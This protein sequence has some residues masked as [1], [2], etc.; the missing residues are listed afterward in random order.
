MAAPIDPFQAAFHSVINDFKDKLS[1]T[2]LYNEIL[3][4]TSID[5]VYDATDKLQKK[6]AEDGHLRHLSKIETYLERLREYSGAIDTFV[7]TKPSVLAL[8]WG[9]IKLLIQWTS[10]LKQSFDAIIN[11]TE[12]IGG[13]L[14]EFKEVSQ[15][16]SHNVQLKDVLVLFFQDILDFY[17]VALQFF[18]KP[19]KFLPWR[20]QVPI[21]CAWSFDKLA[22]QGWRYVFESLWP[23]QRDRIK[24]VITNIGRHTSLMRNE[25]RM[26]H[27]R[28]ERDAR[29]RAL[30]HFEKTDRSNRQQEYNIIKT[31]ISPKSY[32][33]KL[34][35]LYGR[36]CEGTGKWL[37][38]D[39]T[40]AKWLDFADVST[41][42]VWLQGIPGAGRLNPIMRV[43]GCF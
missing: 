42:I 9:P 23:K 11:T 4:T 25:V 12:E 1:D 7:Q 6:Q 33:D 24:L 21:L 31:G 20:L 37:I 3:K 10:I 18:S 43:I 15:L 14:P 30:E 8:I 17:L 27:I 41:K 34:D 22:S 32:D 5:E 40:F 16:F 28:E 13:L 2:K 29:L 26:E 38:R 36:I 39:P 19:S 35:W